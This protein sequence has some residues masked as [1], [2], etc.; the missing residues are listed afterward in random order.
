[1]GKTVLLVEDEPHIIEALS[2][3]LEQAGWAVHAHSDG[4]DAT[5]IAA[6]IKPDVV[7]LD[8]MLPNK[9][10]FDILREIRARPDLNGLPVLMLTAKG[11][12]KDRAAAEAAGADLFMT[13]PFSNQEIVEAA[14]KLATTT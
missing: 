4:G 13:K 5:E 14:N 9:S 7:I 12:T 10:G 8:A 6:S 1:M 3:L 11:Q 2:F